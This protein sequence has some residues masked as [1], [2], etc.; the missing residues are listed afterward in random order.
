MFVRENDT[1]KRVPANRRAAPLPTEGQHQEW[2]GLR[3]LRIG[4]VRDL[5]KRE[6]G[7]A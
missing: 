5:P 1:G 6:N 7:F 2:R 3:G 4:A